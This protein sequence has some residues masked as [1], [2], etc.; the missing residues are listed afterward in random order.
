MALMASAWTLSSLTSLNI[1]SWVPA[2]PTHADQS[3]PASGSWFGLAAVMV[4]AG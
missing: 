1:A 4:L 2:E 3:A